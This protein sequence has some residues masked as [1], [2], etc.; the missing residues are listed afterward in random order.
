MS[1]TY[2][3]VYS[4][5]AIG[6]LKEI[7]TYIAFTLMVP[8]TAEKKERHTSAVPFLMLKCVEIR[9]T[10]DHCIKRANPCFVVVS[11]DDNCQWRTVD[12]SSFA[13]LCKTFFALNSDH[14]LK[15]EADEKGNYRLR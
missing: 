13:D 7:Y 5:E 1:D 10:L 12:A 14:V 3:V 4:P 11:A 9:L 15:K 8:E 2:S 6:D